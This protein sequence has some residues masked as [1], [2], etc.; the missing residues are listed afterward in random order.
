MEQPIDIANLDQGLDRD[1]LKKLK[2][3]FLAISEERL[4]RTRLGLN[5]RQQLVLDT[6]AALFHY[7][8][9]GLPGYVS[10]KTPA[11]LSNFK[12]DNRT[13]LAVK[14]LSRSFNF[15][16][17]AG[18]N[19]DIYAIFIMGSVGTIAHGSH[20]DLDV[21]VCYRPGL[22]A[23]SVQ[24]LTHKGERISRWAQTL[25]AEV[26]CFP[27]DSEAFKSGQDETL[28][29]ESSG[30]SQHYLLLDEFYRTA[31]WLGGRI[32]LWWFIPPEREHDYDHCA[33]LLLRKQFIRPKEVL[34]FGST[35]KIPAGEYIGA[36]IWH[37]Y[38]GID[39]PYKS[40]LK[41][42]LL[43]AYAS[44]HPQGMPLSVDFKKL[45]Y[46]GATEIDTLDAY[47]RLYWHLEEYLSRRKESKRLELI[48]RAF[49]FKV[50]CPLTRKPRQQNRLGWQW[51]IM[52]AMADQ[53]G[54][55]KDALTLLDNRQ[56]WKAGQVKLEKHH[57]VHELIT[58]YRFITQ[59]AGK[60]KAKNVID[61]SELEV[62]GHK[63][64]AAFDRKA[65]KIEF[66]N[67]DISNSITESM[68]LLRHR[69]QRPSNERWSVYAL[70]N[71]ATPASRHL[72]LKQSSQLNEILC[73]SLANGVIDPQTEILIEGANIKPNA[74]RQYMSS[75]LACIPLPLAKPDHRDFQNASTLK[76]VMVFANLTATTLDDDA[77]SLSQRNQDAFCFGDEP[78]NLVRSIDVVYL[79]SWNEL[80]CLSFPQQA[81]QK[82]TQRYWQ[83]CQAQAASHLPE[84]TV[85]CSRSPIST[86]ICARMKDYFSQLN[87]AI[88]G[89]AAKHSNK[90]LRFIFQ[91]DTRY[92]L[93]HEQDQHTLLQSFDSEELLTEAVQK[94]RSQPNYWHLDS[95]AMHN[96][97]LRLVLENSAAPGIKIFFY[98]PATNRARLYFVDDYQNI[99]LLQF[100]FGRLMSLLQSLHQFIRHIT[101]QALVT[102]YDEQESF[103]VY[104]VNFYQL[105]RDN[106]RWRHCE[107]LPVAA[108]TKEPTEFEVKAIA[109]PGQSRPVEYRFICDQ[110]ELEGDLASQL[111]ATARMIRAHRGLAEAYPLYISDLDLSQCRELIAGGRDLL[112]SDYLNA[113]NH[114]EQ[115][116]NTR[117]GFINQL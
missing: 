50:Q 101:Q 31:I 45:V 73:W 17:P 46:S 54:W 84:I 23:A 53:W 60:I 12:P 35:A 21:W 16:E 102:H 107:H 66:I 38:K 98:L 5:D 62:L 49:Y 100:P 36:G 42:L 2:K 59:F 105:K 114:L 93:L 10:H 86:V 41:L 74:I 99:T 64:H 91:T 71:R 89:S 104:P 48:R 110:T 77:V 85:Y 13:K 68:L 1:Q 82:F 51:K 111:D 27:M 94:P 69:P 30:S 87:E 28:D 20:S 57:L 63:L 92:H 75:L 90:S 9:P 72:L 8:H 47:V 103:G 4:A 26:H 78:H 109:E 115:L 116:I 43:E 70:P 52:Q 81:L 56:E 80:V 7:N 44:Q 88:A 6:L 34:D 108:E 117:T 113:K 39:S 3:R 67:P 14:R 19:N 22:D 55:R 25:G 18:R 76:K 32:P 15:N 37:L 97:P 95:R 33:D 24:L 58:S 112:L 79:T 65:G 29:E 96:D 106:G 61:K 11:K 40:V 83:L